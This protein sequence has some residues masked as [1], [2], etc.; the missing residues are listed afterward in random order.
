MPDSYSK[1]ALMVSGRPDAVQKYLTSMKPLDEQK[2]DLG[3]GGV[4]MTQID[5]ARKNIR[6]TQGLQ[7]KDLARAVNKATGGGKAAL[8]DDLFEKGSMLSI[9]VNLPPSLP[10]KRWETEKKLRLLIGEQMKSTDEI[11]DIHISLQNEEESYDLVATTGYVRIPCFHY[12]YAHSMVNHLN[13]TNTSHFKFSATF[14][15]QSIRH[16]TKTWGHSQSVPAWDWSYDGEAA[17]KN[18]TKTI[19][20]KQ[21]LTLSLQKDTFEERLEKLEKVANFCLTDVSKEK[22][23]NNNGLWQKELDVLVG[24]KTYQVGNLIKEA[25]SLHSVLHKVASFILQHLNS[26]RCLQGMLD[27]GGNEDIMAVKPHDTFL[28]LD[29]DF[30]LLMDYIRDTDNNIME[31]FLFK[32]SQSKTPSQSQ[33]GIMVI[34]YLITGG[35]KECLFLDCGV[36]L[37]G[38]VT[39]IAHDP[40]K[41]VITSML[42]KHVS[43]EFYNR[44]ILQN[45]RANEEACSSSCTI[46]ELQGWNTISDGGQC[47]Q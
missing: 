41:R 35:G 26:L 17:P 7:G 14:E 43:T 16:Q 11:F 27:M 2:K 15:A 20:D 46:E 37:S 31:N 13:M 9:R 18:H 40:Q 32:G 10:S 45:I 22:I 33:G 5:Q 34:K 21:L 23:G 12:M 29:K 44:M 1:L 4:R 6:N 19:S 25:Q 3:D 30:P 8:F 47:G 39:A 24:L 38:S 36:I 28:S 42:S